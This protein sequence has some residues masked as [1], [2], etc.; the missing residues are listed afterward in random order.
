MLIRAGYDIAYECADD[1]AELAC[2]LLPIKSAF[3]LSESETLDGRPRRRG[4]MR[5]M[6][7]RQ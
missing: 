5:R 3:Q 2:G 6:I 7:A 1:A 4:P